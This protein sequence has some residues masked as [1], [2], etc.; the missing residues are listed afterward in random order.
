MREIF[1]TVILLAT[2]FTAVAQEKPIDSYYA[3][4]S[5]RDHFNSNGERLQ[6]AAAIIRQDR[7]NFHLYRKRD[8]EDDSD[9]VFSDKENRARL[10]T[11]VNNGRF[12]DGAEKEI[13]N[14]TPLIHVEIYEDSIVVKL[15]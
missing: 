10:E 3:R 12:Y 2:I 6:S 5:D 14:S 15:K 13:L 9:N 8:A 1:A 4:L 7:A 11:M